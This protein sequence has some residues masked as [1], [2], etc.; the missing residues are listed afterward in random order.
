[1]EVSQCHFTHFLLHQLEIPPYWMTKSVREASL[2]TKYDSDNFPE[3]LELNSSFEIVNKGKVFLIWLLRKYGFYGVLLMASY[4]NI[5]FDLCGIC[6]GHFLMP[7]WTF[8]LATFLGKAVIRNLYQS[9][10]YVMICRYGDI[11]LHF[12]LFMMKL[13]TSILKE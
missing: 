10:F 11:F 6:C 12:Y 7:F 1:M 4:P 8:F 2:K 9:I 13:A 5:A 3:E